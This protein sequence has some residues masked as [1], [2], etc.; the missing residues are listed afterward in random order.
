MDKNVDVIVILFI[1]IYLFG[2]LLYTFL[3][4]LLLHK[5]ERNFHNFHT[6]NVLEA[7]ANFLNVLWEILCQDKGADK[8]GI[9]LFLHKGKLKKNMFKL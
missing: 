9:G 4:V 8:S 3:C 5:Y 2:I 1:F 7:D 6:K